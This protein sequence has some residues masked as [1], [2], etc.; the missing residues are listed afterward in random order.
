MLDALDDAERDTLAALLRKL[1]EAA[2]A[3]GGELM[4][5]PD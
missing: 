2:E 5:P 3:E 4:P 1:A